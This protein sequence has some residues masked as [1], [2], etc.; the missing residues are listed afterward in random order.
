MQHERPHPHVAIPLEQGLFFNLDVEE[1][2]AFTAVA[3]PLEQGLFFNIWRGV[4]RSQVFVAIPLEQGLFFN[5]EVSFPSLFSICC[6][7]RFQLLLL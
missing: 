4:T 1:A 2:K 7:I 5:S 6:K 3:I